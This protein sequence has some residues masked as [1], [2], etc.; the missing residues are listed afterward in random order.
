M[1]YHHE[2]T[3]IDQ[4]L[5]PTNLRGSSLTIQENMSDPPVVSHVK[6]D[7]L[8]MSY[9]QLKPHLRKS[10]FLLST[11]EEFPLTVEKLREMIEKRY[12][13]LEKQP[14]RLQYLLYGEPE[15]NTRTL[16]D[17]GELQRELKK[18]SV[19]GR[20]F[21]LF[22]NCI[23]GQFPP[24]EFKLPL[25]ADPRETE[26]YTMVSF[27]S[28]SRIEDTNQTTS[29]LQRMW[30][31]FR[32]LGRVYVANEGVN[33][34]MAIPTN[35]FEDFKNVTKDNRLFHE[36]R[37]NTDPAIPKEEYFK[38]KPFRA[39]HIRI[40]DQIVAD[41]LDEA[42]NWKNAGHEL[43]P[44]EWHK[45]LDDPSAIILDCRN[46]YETDVGIFDGA[47]PLNTTF[48]RE[49]WVALDEALKGKPKDT[50]VL[51]YC[52]GGI[53]CVKINAYLEQKMGFI[54]THRLKGGVIAYRR[55]LEEQ[56]RG[57]SDNVSSIPSKFKGVNYVFDERIVERIT[58]DCV[59][60]CESCGTPN[61]SFTNCKN[62]NC[63]VRDTFETSY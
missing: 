52:T 35:I 55:E 32:A 61:D 58:E 9:L 57:R 2:A 28:F 37:F 6:I 5:E 26:S 56:R 46:T 43:D 25:S 3:L 40:R 42:L 16:T 48:F 27:F 34:Q 29:E 10:R 14:Y 39:L 20:A 7:P 13:G 17:D 49:S 38:S 60:K 53:R 51:T 24:P 8:I 4:P 63:N 30:T 45:A 18:A 31:P 21:Q 47:I 11:K 44:M 50:P 19:K 62:V 33:A 12:P 15:E 54:N 59:G 1:L 22:V 23:M 41:G 36:S